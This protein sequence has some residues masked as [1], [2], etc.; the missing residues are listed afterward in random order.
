MTQKLKRLAAVLLILSLLLS[1]VPVVSAQEEAPESID[2]CCNTVRV[3]ETK[4]M[5]RPAFTGKLAEI[6][7]QR[8][9]DTFRYLDDF[10]VK[11]H[12]EAALL[13]P[14]GDEEDKEVLRTLADVITK[15]CETDKEK[16]DAVSSWVARNIFYDVETSAYASDTFYRRT[17][18]CL[19]YAFL[20]QTLLRMEGI[21]A[22]LG[23]GWRGDMEANTVSL[24]D[25]VGHAWVFVYIDGQ[26]EL[27]DPLWL[28]ESTTD[29][30]YMAR[31]IY[32]DTVEF[33]TP[34]YDEENL[35]PEPP[36]KT[37]AYYTGE[38]AYLYSD[39]WQNT[40]GLLTNFVNNIT[41]SFL[42]YQDEP[43]TGISD[44]WII[45]DESVDKAQ[46]TRGQIYNTGWMSY[47]DIRLDQQMGLTYAFPNGMLIDG[48]VMSYN[49]QDYMMYSNQCLSIY[50]DE[51]DYSIT[52]GLLTLPTGYQGKFLDVP[53]GEQF[54]TE[55]YTLTVENRTPEVA[56]ADIDGNVA[57]L[58]EGYGEFLYTV[59]RNEDNAL[60][61]S[62]ILQII[63]SNEERIPD[64]S[65]YGAVEP[66]PTEPS[67]PE[68]PTEPTEPVEPPVFNDMEAGSWYEESVNFMVEQGLMNGVGNGRFNPKG[69]VTRAMLVTILYRAA[70]EPSVKALSNPFTDVPN[71]QWY[72]NAI[73][74]AA[75]EGIVTG[76]KP[77]RFNPNGNIT[78]E[79]IATILYRYE[80]SPVAE[81][82]LPPFADN[83]QISAYA[84][85]PMNWAIAEG[86]INGV[87]GGFL[88]PTN[89]ATRAQI[90]TILARYLTK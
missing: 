83:R 16:A 41:V 27:Y 21:P 9:E 1:I 73:I 64:Y 70:G 8:V 11:A 26:W 5:Q 66:P 55:E 2:R 12:P 7:P 22:V 86:L 37:R 80:G 68:D 65:D 71:G 19:S 87:G 58:Q 69:N 44:G 40:I 62:A 59:M 47:G 45:L 84:L 78:R 18:N 72:S 10:Y 14:Y 30:D 28:K 88:A 63:V 20:I 52:D 33:I 24:F 51:E 79:Q 29:R 15:D 17:G 56:V 77:D 90:A 61:G 38:A 67:E 54:R 6:T 85:K 42:T 46:M 23:D 89:T 39:V 76:V 31:W 75:S 53:W 60:M 32:F 3:R 36:E 50:A 25:M 43:E 48:T 57:C 74:W 82:T 35:P 13:T 34:C 49:G 4:A 81:D